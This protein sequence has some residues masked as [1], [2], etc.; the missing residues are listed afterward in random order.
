MKNQANFNTNKIHYCI[1]F[2]SLI[3][4]FLEANAQTTTFKMGD[5]LFLSPNDEFLDVRLSK[6][7][8]VKVGDDNHYRNLVYYD[9]HPFTGTIMK[10]KGLYHDGNQIIGSFARY[11]EDE[12]DSSFFCINYLN[13]RFYKDYLLN[14]D[15][16]KTKLWFD[17]NG[18]PDKS[19]YVVVKKIKSADVQN[20]PEI[21]P[22]FITLSRLVSE[23]D[24]YDDGNLGVFNHR[25]NSEKVSIFPAGIQSL[26]ELVIKYSIL[27]PELSNCNLVDTIFFGFSNNHLLTLTYK[28]ECESKIEFDNSKFILDMPVFDAATNYGNDFINVDYSKLLFSSDFDE[29]STSRRYFIET[30][31]SFG[32]GSFFSA[33]ENLPKWAKITTKGY[34]LEVYFDKVKTTK[35]AKRMSL[36]ET[37]NT[38]G[39][40]GPY[41]DPIYHIAAPIKS[42][43]IIGD[44]ND[45]FGKTKHTKSN[46]AISEDM[47]YQLSSE[48]WYNSDTVLINTAGDLKNGI[49]DRFEYKSNIRQDRYEGFTS[50]IIQHKTA[51]SYIIEAHGKLAFDTSL[52][53]DIKS[54]VLEAI[55]KNTD[56]DHHKLLH[57]IPDGKSTFIYSDGTQKQFKYKEGALIID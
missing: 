38:E 56:E 46:Y 31:L 8:D 13:G 15:F 24:F 50:L 11:T 9:G 32:S 4:S 3:L 51:N 18:N 28:D 5:T 55:N 2:I 6:F 42:F 17:K 21:N 41:H 40:N 12:N 47:K 35:E 43:I 23:I 10:N 34:S 45:D 53:K 22:K 1:F 57:L 36:K 20:V 48:Y 54:F 14:N 29:F 16:V 27:N 49:L 44:I 26:E 33:L 7:S 30:F 25:G 39:Y 37:F 52:G 19:G